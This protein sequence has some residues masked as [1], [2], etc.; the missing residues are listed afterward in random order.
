MGV[1]SKKRQDGTKAWYYDFMYNK[2]RYRGVGGVTKTQA[3]RTQDKIRS[4][5]L[6]GEYELENKVRNPRIEVFA[7]TY[8][9]RRQY[10]RSRR[11]DACAVKHVLD[12]FSGRVLSQITPADVEDY[13][14]KRRESRV[15]NGTINRELACFKRMFNLAIK[16]GDAKKNPINNVD[17]LEEPPGRTRFLSQDEAAR[18]ITSCA[19]HLRPIV[20]TA[21]NTGMRLGEILGLTWD[22]IHIENVIDPYVELTV[23]KN[24]KTR[25]VPLN[26]DVVEL[27]AELKK[28]KC[29]QHVFLS[30]HKK[31]LKSVRKPFEAALKKAGIL[32]FRFHDLRHTFASHFVMNS[33]DLLTL[34]EILGHHS[35]KMVERYAHL[36]AA[37]KR[38]QVNNLNGVFSNCHL[39]ATSDK[40]LKM[41]GGDK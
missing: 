14:A 31:Q 38:R 4:K 5:V 22:R 19:T 18:L 34:K 28:N 25:Y 3:Q 10:L 26:N 6:N 17:F 27:F 16:W 24:N 13:I 33:G 15:S 7:E 32:D 29:S 11:R 12:Q 21:L 35:V 1:Y 30:T 37:H 8:L 39:N 23:T 41:S 2:V 40:I 9:K 36:G 20:I